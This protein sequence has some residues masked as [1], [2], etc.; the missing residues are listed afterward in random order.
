VHPCLQLVEQT[1]SAELA[2]ESLTRAPAV[3]GVVA[4]RADGRY[5]PGHRGWLKVKRQR[6]ADCVVV[7]IAGD[8]RMPML[9]LGLRDAAGQL[10]TFGVTRTVPESLAA[11]IV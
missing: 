3:E 10:R 6:T 9:V 4:K 7:G 1:A 5:R 11:P 8:E 2:R